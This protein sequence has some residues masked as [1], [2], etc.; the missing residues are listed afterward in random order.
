MYTSVPGKPRVPASVSLLIAPILLANYGPSRLVSPPPPPAAVPGHVRR[1]LNR[2]AFTRWMGTT[3]P[4]A[5]AFASAPGALCP[6]VRPRGGN[7]WNPSLGCS[8]RAI[9]DGARYNCWFSL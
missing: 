6:V 9:A 8:Q 4:L 2:I 1:T 7:T 3:V 5:F